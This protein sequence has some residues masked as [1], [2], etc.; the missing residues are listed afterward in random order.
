MPESIVSFQ[1]EEDVLDVGCETEILRKKTVFRTN[2]TRLECTATPLRELLTCWLSG[3]WSVWPC[4]K[5]MI[6]D[7][8][9]GITLYEETVIDVFIWQMSHDIR[10]PETAY[11]QCCRHWVEVSGLSTGSDHP[12]QQK[13]WCRERELLGFKSADVWKL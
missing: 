12:R 9:F 11:V 13:E 2:I 6:Y 8:Q 4:I 3:Y 10:T 7:F 5:L 1:T